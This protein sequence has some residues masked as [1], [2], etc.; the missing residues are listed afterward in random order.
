MKKIYSNSYIIISA[1]L[2]INARI[3]HAQQEQLTFFGKAEPVPELNSAYDENFLAVDYAGDKLV[4]S[5]K[6]HPGNVGGSKNP[7]DIWF[8]LNDTIWSNPSPSTNVDAVQIVTPVGFVEKGTKLIYATTRLNYTRYETT[9]WSAGFSNGQLDNV[10]VLSVPYFSNQSAHLS[11]SL[12]FDGRYMLLSMESRT[13]FGV[14]DLYV[15]QRMDDGSWSAPKNLGYAVN[16]PFQEYTPFLAADNETLIFASNGRD[17]GMGSFDLYMARRLDDTWQNWSP[18]VNLG[19]Q[20]NTQ[21]SE[22]S[23]V[24]PPGSDYAYFVSTTDSDGYGDVKKIRVTSQIKENLE[25]DVPVLEVVAEKLLSQKWIVLRDSDTGLEIPGSM[26]VSNDTMNLQL[27]APVSLAYDRLPDVRIDAASPGYMGRQQFLTSAMLSSMDTVFV[28]L[29]AL[30]VGATIKMEHVLFYQGT[31]NIIEGSEKEI[32][33]VVLL[34]VE[35]PSMRI[36][37][38]GHTD[39][40]GDPVLNYELSKERVDEIRNYMMARG[41]AYKRITGKGYGG[42]APIAPNDTEENRKLN[43]R[44][45]FVII[46]N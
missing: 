8:A 31:A 30:R 21:G 5:R 28:D 24:L 15:V 45:E 14:E 19:Q 3:V 22:M 25:A 37:L 16:T 46:S 32:E 2:L 10:Q 1:L 33:R 7:G 20:I 44:V 38:R 6:Y 35:N 36:E 11:G 12:S 27:D 18:P 42:N 9:L 17:G 29:Q 34:M 13:S 40:N 41:I 4:F 43:R 39:N 23:F 26:Q